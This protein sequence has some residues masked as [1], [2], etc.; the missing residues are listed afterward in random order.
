MEVILG[1][2]VGC[3]WQGHCP[4]GDGGSVGQT[5]LLVLIG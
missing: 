4:L 5:A 1:K 3:L 2:K